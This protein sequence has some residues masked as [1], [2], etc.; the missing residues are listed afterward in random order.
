[1]KERG[2]PRMGKEGGRKT[3]TETEKELDFAQSLNNLIS[4]YFQICTSE[5][6][7]VYQ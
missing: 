7:A 6:S 5:S 3:E 4:K 1:M 2:A